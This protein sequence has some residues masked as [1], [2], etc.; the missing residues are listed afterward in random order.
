[1]LGSKAPMRA[2]GRACDGQALSKGL[3]G[4]PRYLHNVSD[5]W[6]NTIRMQCLHAQ[7]KP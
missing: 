6:R 1:M 4:C 3:R 7:N 5:G 2:S